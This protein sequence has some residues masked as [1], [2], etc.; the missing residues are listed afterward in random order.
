[1]LKQIKNLGDY[2]TKCR[3]NIQGYQNQN[4][5]FYAINTGRTS[6]VYIY[7]IIAADKNFNPINCINLLSF[8]Y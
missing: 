5:G 1:V 2:T 8:S 3:E 4:S 6:E 7:I